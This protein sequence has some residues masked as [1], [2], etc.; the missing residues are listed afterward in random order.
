ML[1]VPV[2][3]KGEL[4]R[5]GAAALGD[6]PRGAEE[7]WRDTGEGPRRAE[8]FREVGVPFAL[9]APRWALSMAAT[10]IEAIKR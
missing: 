5:E 6:A 9:E 7:V 1:G 4:L 2:L 10:D 3:S 8:G